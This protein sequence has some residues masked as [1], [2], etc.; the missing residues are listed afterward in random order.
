MQME[1][2]GRAPAGVAADPAGWKQ[3][4]PRPALRRA[5]VFPVERVRQGDC[6][7]SPAQVRSVQAS[8]DLQVVKEFALHKGWKRNGPVFLSFTA[9]NKD[10]LSIEVKV[11]DA[12]LQCF[13][14]SEARAV[15]Q[16]R[17]QPGDSGQLTEDRS[18]FRTRHHHWQGGGH[19][20][21][22]KVAQGREV[23]LDDVFVE[24]EEGGEGLIL[25]RGGD[26]LI[27]GQ[28][29]QEGLDVALAHVARMAL[30]VKQDVAAD[31]CGVGIGS[32]GAVVPEAEGIA[33]LIEELGRAWGLG[34]H[35][36][37]IERIVPLARVRCSE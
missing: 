24:K 1:A 23:P 21:A 13:V 3:E 37:L 31:P 14:Q 26:G 9:A 11:L 4:L 35:A 30:V 25:C 22:R 15:E 16:C 32:A 10:L 34:G 20:S 27:D 29:C 12:Q 33:Q 6:A 19:S 2:R 17:D 28:V 8:H 36:T 7:E 18:D 5:R